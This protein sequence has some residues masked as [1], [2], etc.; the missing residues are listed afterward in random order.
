MRFASAGDYISAGRSAAASGLEAIIAARK[1]SPNFQGI[2]E[3]GQQEELKNFVSDIDRRSDTAIAKMKAEQYVEE[4]R[5]AESMRQA[6]RDNH[7]A[8]RKAGII[9]AAGGYAAKALK[10][11]SEL[12]IPEGMYKSLSDEI[13]KQKEVI[14]SLSTKTGDSDS[15]T[16]TPSDAVTKLKDNLT[17]LQEQRSGIISDIEGLN[18]GSAGTPGTSGEPAG[19]SAS[20]LT[21]DS[22]TSEQLKDLSYVVSAEAARGTDDEYAVA[23]SVLNRVN[24][25]K[26]PGSI[27]AVMRQPGQYQAITDGKAYFDNDLASK[28]SSP[29]GRAKL[30]KYLG[31]LNGRTDFKGQSQL[32]NR[33]ADEDPMAHPSGNFYHYHYQ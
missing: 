15:S 29:E 26:F 7:S 30:T 2:A 27:S 23:A 3:Q 10:K 13:E 32:H 24:S 20:S 4:E 28:F 8:V 33:V 31:I 9:A 19:N 17:K 11:P 6:K 14:E 12:K 22:L 1:N 5:L 25:D 21:V 18:G 16:Y